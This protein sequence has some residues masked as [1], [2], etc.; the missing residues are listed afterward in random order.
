V[1]PSLVLLAVLAA[2]T[3][4]DPLARVN[5]R[6]V[7]VDVVVRD[8]AGA[9][10]GLQQS[11][12]TV[13]D[14]GK[15]QRIATFVVSLRKRADPSP[16]PLAPGTVSNRLNQL[17]ETPVGA[18]VVLL[19][20]LNT[21]LEHQSEV[22][23]Q[24]LA[25]LSTLTTEDRLA[26]YTLNKTLRVVQD[27]T[28][29]P[30][31]LIAAAK[32]LSPEQ[33]VD[34]GTP[35]LVTDLPVTG[36][37][38]TDNMTKNAAAEM[39]D[40]A[41]QNR[42]EITVAALEM[43]AR[44]L[45]GLPGRKKLVWFS[46]SFP[47]FFS[48]Q[49]SRVGATQIEQFDYTRYIDHAV[50]ALN[51][52]NVAVYPIDPRPIGVGDVFFAPG[53][54]T[55]NL[56]A[57]KTGGMSQYVI[58]D[59]AGAMQNVMQDDDIVYTLGFYP[60]DDKLDGAF[61]PL[62][63]KVA[64]SGVELRSRKGYFAADTKAP[65]A[66]Q[67]R[68]SMKELFSSPLEATGLGLTAIAHPLSGQFG[69]YQLDVRLNIN[70]LHLEAERAK[71]GTPVWVARLDFVTQFAAGKPPYGTGEHIQITLTEE[72][73]RQVLHDGFLLR[74]VIAAEQPSEIR[75]AVQDRATGETGSLRLNLTTDLADH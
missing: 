27:F 70:E 2:Q 5:T 28:G 43:I 10:A 1:F 31:V 67:R 38:I 59:L 29:D 35:D 48:E 4:P 61:H 14:K 13:L 3:A 54:D 34:L 53:I 22:R 15:P 75:I 36:D 40:R 41:R 63:V 7:E 6:L 60:R 23:R 37:A 42:A 47:A 69:M 64:R 62:A 24:M 72:R 55:M 21:E 17:G 68:E 65:D 9:V 57:G 26:F 56:I 25:Y 8:K 11:D 50:R 49:R 12:F 58:N 71:N 44:H 74:R 45:S 66:K 16:A 52:A 39:T 51:D 20:M 33:S 46:A 30:N 73:L 19:D 32:R 18:T